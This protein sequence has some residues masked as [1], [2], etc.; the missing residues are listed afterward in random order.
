M[1]FL[2]FPSIVE[3]FLNRL[4]LAEL[5][6]VNICRPFACPLRMTM[7][8]GDQLMHRQPYR[9]TCPLPFTVNRF[10]TAFLVFSLV[11]NDRISMDGSIQKG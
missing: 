2:I 5:F 8:D 4:F 11:P 6:F 10:A 7:N 3:V 1:F 9:L